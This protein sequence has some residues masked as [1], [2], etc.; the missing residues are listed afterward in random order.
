[1]IHTLKHK[2]QTLLVLGLFAGLYILASQAIDFNL[3]VFLTSIP[4]FIRFIIVEFLPPNLTALPL[5]VES[6][7][8]TIFV[9]I[10]AS[11]SGA[12]LAFGFALLIAKR[13]TP[14][15]KIAIV[16][17][18]A[19][20]FVRNIPM[21]VWASLFVIIVGIGITAGVVALVFFSVSFLSRVFAD[22]LDDIDKGTLEALRANG[23]SK[24]ALIHH[25]MIPE[26]LPTFYGW[27]LFLFEINIKASSILGLVG[28][29]G[30]GYELKKSLDLFKYHDASALILVIV[31]L[32]ITV[33]IISNKIRKAIL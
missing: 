1:M 5:Y 4:G 11:V 15:P 20:A 16:I 21:M 23:A 31:V 18:G 17:R 10:L 8:N 28:A 6:I 14:F 12:I 29:G 2:W 25:V 24:L 13:T 27:V 7:L 32:M 30:L 33:E 19:L 3:A 22:A 26:F 9:S